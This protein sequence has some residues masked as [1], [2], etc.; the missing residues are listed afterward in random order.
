MLYLDT[1]FVHFQCIPNKYFYFGVNKSWII[2]WKSSPPNLIFGTYL[3]IWQF[4][5]TWT[6]TILSN[7]HMDK[8]KKWIVSITFR[9]KHDSGA[10]I[11]H[12]LDKILESWDLET[13]ASLIVGLV[14]NTNLFIFCAS[15]IIQNIQKS[16]HGWK[17]AQWK[18]V[19]KS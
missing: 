3:K 6:K 11:L 1:N 7:V 14:L 17:F 5:I 2:G 16:G 9:H 8:M 12:I 19:Y 4:E 15:A 13:I 18:M 10:E